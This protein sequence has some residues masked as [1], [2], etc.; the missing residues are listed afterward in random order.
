M[1]VRAVEMI[2]TPNYTSFFLPKSKL[3]HHS[4]SFIKSGPQCMFF[5]N[6]TVV[7]TY[8][9]LAVS[10]EDAEVPTPVREK[11]CSRILQKKSCSSVAGEHALCDLGNATSLTPMI[12]LS[13]LV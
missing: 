6:F 8:Y 10:K 13:F 4:S 12:W 7:P 3:D 1:T 11:S 2:S 9:L 5:L